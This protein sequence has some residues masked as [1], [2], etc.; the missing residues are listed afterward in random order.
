[1]APNTSE[2]TQGII[3]KVSVVALFWACVSLIL[4]NPKMAEGFGK[5]VLCMPLLLAGC[6]T[7]TVAFAIVGIGWLC[8]HAA[9]TS[10]FKHL[11]TYYKSFKQRVCPIVEPPD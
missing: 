8:G 1:M 3:G 11:G 5:M 4:N 2:K 10:F 9:S 7:V 6:V